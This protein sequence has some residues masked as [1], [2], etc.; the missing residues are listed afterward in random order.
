MTRK[1]GAEGAFPS[2][3]IGSG[4][5]DPGDVGKIEG[6]P[7]A[8]LED[9]HDGALPVFLDWGR[10]GKSAGDRETEQCNQAGDAYVLPH[11]LLLCNRRRDDGACLAATILTTLRKQEW[12][13]GICTMA[14]NETRHKELGQGSTWGC[15]ARSTNPIQ[16]KVESPQWIFLRL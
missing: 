10:L 3:C 6:L 13:H 4:K 11:V 2:G 9:D 7:V 5:L 1:G 12:F 16:S 15:G 8:I 14:T